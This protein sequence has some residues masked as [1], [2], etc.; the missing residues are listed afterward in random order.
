MIGAPNRRSRSATNASDASVRIDSKPGSELPCT[1][2][3][4]AGVVAEAGVIG[5]H[6][7]KECAI[8]QGAQEI[9]RREG[10]SKQLVLSAQPAP[11]SLLSNLRH[12]G[13]LT[14]VRGYG[15]GRPTEVAASGRDR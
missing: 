14:R 13:G 10:F 4:V 12:M 5:I 2:M 7:I 15:E 11:G 3:P 1:W 8:W 9:G 6:D